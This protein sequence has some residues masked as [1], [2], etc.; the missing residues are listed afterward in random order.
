MALHTSAFYSGLSLDDTTFGVVVVPAPGVTL[1]EAEA[2]LDTAIADFLEEGIDE[3]QFERMKMQ[4]RASDIYARRQPAGA[5][6]A[7]RRRR[8]TTGLS[9]ED[10]EAWPEIL[11]GRHRR[12]RHRSRAAGLRPAPIP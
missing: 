10:V 5:R 1:E 7:L 12:R 6:A 8:S 4:I 3:A 11:A 9:I 2:A